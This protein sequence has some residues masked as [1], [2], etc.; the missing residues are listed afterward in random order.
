M[1]VNAVSSITEVSTASTVDATST[2]GAT[3]DVD[4][5]NAPPPHRE[6]SRKVH[7][8]Y[9]LMLVHRISGL[10]NSLSI[11]GHFDCPE[12]P[13][14]EGR[15]RYGAALAAVARANSFL[16]AFPDYKIW[17]CSKSVHVWISGRVLTEEEQYM[18][19]YYY[20]IETVGE[21]LLCLVASKPRRPQPKQVVKVSEVA[22]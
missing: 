12:A 7:I 4:V 14:Y 20:D 10:A 11:D 2:V 16:T 19:F 15:E 6:A 13:Q 9:R 17:E 8:N 22:S 18:N 1:S 21:N 5:F 3:S